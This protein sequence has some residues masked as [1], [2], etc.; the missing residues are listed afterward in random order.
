MIGIVID[1]T[2]KSSLPGCSLFSPCEINHY[3][4]YEISLVKPHPIFAGVDPDDLT[5]NKGVAGFFAR[6]THSPIPAGAEVLITLPDDMPV[7]YIDRVSTKGTILV[8]AGRDLFANRMQ[9]K[10]TDRISVQLLKWVYEESSFMKSS[11]GGK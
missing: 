6:G 8:H 1:D 2:S 4:D 7:T 11:G 10:S 9:G 5:F 3:T